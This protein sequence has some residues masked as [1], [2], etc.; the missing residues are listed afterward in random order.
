MIPMIAAALGGAMM[1]FAA[2]R[3]LRPRA[4]FGERLY[5]LAT[6]GWAAFGAAIYYPALLGRFAPL[7]LVHNPLLVTVFGFGLVALGVYGASMMIGD[8]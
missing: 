4:R 6:G 3:G 1:I 5:A 7:G 8:G 2:L